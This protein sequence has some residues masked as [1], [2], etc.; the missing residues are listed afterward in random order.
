VLTVGRCEEAIVVYQL[1]GFRCSSSGSWN[2]SDA[3]TKGP[4]SEKPFGYLYTFLITWFLLLSVQTTSFRADPE[5]RAL[6]LDSGGMLPSK[7]FSAHSFSLDFL[8]ILP[9]NL[10]SPIQTNVKDLLKED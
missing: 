2:F 8:V 3:Q 5:T 6:D 9:P 10:V 1:K 4:Y 7:G